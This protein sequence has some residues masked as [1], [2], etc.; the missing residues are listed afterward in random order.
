MLEKRKY[1]KWNILDSL[2]ESQLL[3]KT[4]VRTNFIRLLFEI[5][6]T[7]NPFLK[8]FSEHFDQLVKD[9]IEI[10]PHKETRIWKSINGKFDNIEGW[11]FLNPIGELSVLR[12]FINSGLF[13]LVEIEAKFSNGQTKDFELK[14]KSDGELKL[15]EVVNIHIPIGLTKH[16]EII[17]CILDKTQKKIIKEID[18]AT[19]IVEMNRLF[20][21][22]VVWYL[23]MDILKSEYAFFNEFNKSLGKTFGMK[24]PTLGFCTYVKDSTNNLIFGE[25]SSI[26]DLNKN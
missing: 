17:D 26:I 20:I 25:A 8:A 10:I 2:Q 13:D 6:V 15:I 16:S 24:H 7:G 18:G 5:E 19:N 11:N 1:S 9:I 12:K 21:L 22:P 23:D 14:Q 4:D 3:L